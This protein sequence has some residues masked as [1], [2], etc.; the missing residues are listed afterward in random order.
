MGIWTG[1]NKISYLLISEPRL[2]EQAERESLFLVAKG[3]RNEEGG[4]NEKEI[5]Y[6][7]LSRNIYEKSSLEDK[8]L[9]SSLPYLETCEISN[10]LQF[11]FES[12][13]KPSLFMMRLI[14]EKRG[15]P[16]R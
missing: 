10:A 3:W 2:W 12:W 14:K 11:L 1:I 16:V 5:N 15:R 13:L 8:S 6:Q 7:L 9:I 4:Q